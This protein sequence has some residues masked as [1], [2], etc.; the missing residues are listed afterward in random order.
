MLVL[1]TDFRDE[2][3]T[4]R[5]FVL[6]TPAITACGKSLPRREYALF[7]STRIKAHWK[8]LHTYVQMGLGWLGL[9]TTIVALFVPDNNT[10][11]VV[12]FAALFMSELLTHTW[13]GYIRYLFKGC[14]GMCSRDGV[15]NIDESDFEDMKYLFGILYHG[16]HHELENA[17]LVDLMGLP[18]YAVMYVS[19]AIAFLGTFIALLVLK[20]AGNDDNRRRRKN[21]DTLDAKAMGGLSAFVGVA[22]GCFVYPLLFLALTTPG[23]KVFASFM[24]HCLNEYYEAKLFR[25]KPA[26]LIWSIVLKAFGDFVGVEDFDDNPDFKDAWN[27]LQSNLDKEDVSGYVKRGGND[28]DPENPQLR[29]VVLTAR[30]KSNTGNSAGPFP[31]QQAPSSVPIRV[32]PAAPPLETGS[33]HDEHGESSMSTELEASEKSRVISTLSDAD[34]LPV[35]IHGERKKKKKKKKRESTSLGQD[36][37][38]VSEDISRAD[39][40]GKK[41]KQS[42]KSKEKQEPSSHDDSEISEDVVR[43]GM[44]KRKK[45]KKEK[46]HVHS[47][48]DESENSD[49]VVHSGI[50]GGR[51]KKRKGKK[52]EHSVRDDSE[53]SES[54]VHASLEG[55][56]NTKGIEKESGDKESE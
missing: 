31:L 11:N 37:S 13:Y 43:A 55:G 41:R 3:M 48:R 6:T 17:Y 5:R 32:L 42:R 24:H 38:G 53:V 16:G 10:N 46:V 8:P 22:M 18:F 20:C 34:L 39:L 36:E 23:G 52:R 29:Q 27:E 49:D 1:R 45:N 51:K 25:K 9:A 19:T 50:D 54:E 21:E 47:E 7:F 12:G 30:D 33:T 26:E 14:G 44:D 40:E 2:I 28:E 4:K 35:S 56:G 15:D